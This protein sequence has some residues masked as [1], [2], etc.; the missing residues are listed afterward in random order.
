MIICIAVKVQT[1]LG[2]YRC[3]MGR[4]TQTRQT[5]SK[6]ID[7]CADP[8]Q[9]AG[10]KGAREREREREN[11]SK[12]KG[13]QA[14]LPQLLDLCV[15]HAQSISILRKSVVRQSNRKTANRVASCIFLLFFLFL[16]PLRECV[17]ELC[18]CVIFCCH[19]YL[20]FSLDRTLLAGGVGRS[21]A[22][23]SSMQQPKT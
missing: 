11:K 5:G 21:V 8:V 20:R 23:S 12:D 2:V 7:C 18:V 6:E 10:R 17:C 1:M 9:R 16:S 4:G 14:E 13:W 15:C 19:I 3:G 22:G